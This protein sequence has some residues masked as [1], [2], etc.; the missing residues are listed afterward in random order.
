[1]P[2]GTLHSHDLKLEKKGRFLV[3]KAARLEFKEYSLT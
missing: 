3:G 1:M 2:Q